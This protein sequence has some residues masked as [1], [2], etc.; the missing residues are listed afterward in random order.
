MSPQFLE[1]PETAK[2]HVSKDCANED[3]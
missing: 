2:D 1:S 3:P